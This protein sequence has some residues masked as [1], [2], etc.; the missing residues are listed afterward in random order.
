MRSATKLRPPLFR[1]E[2]HNL[3]TLTFSAF[4]KK[5]LKL[6]KLL[7][8]PMGTIPN[9]ICHKNKEKCWFISLSKSTF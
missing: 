6:G 8:R 2:K 1:L 4:P 9:F 7:F 3:K 5:E